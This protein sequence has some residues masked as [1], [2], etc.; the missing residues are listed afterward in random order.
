MRQIMSGTVPSVD[1]NDFR[2]MLWN[3]PQM[4]R[5][6][7]HVALIGH[8]GCGKSTLALD[9]LLPMRKF[10]SILATKPYSPTLKQYIKANRY[11]QYEAWPDKVPALKSPRRAIWPD[12]RTVGRIANQ[13]YQIGHA[14]ER[15]YAEGR[16]CVYAD[17]LRYV[18]DDLN[19]STLVELMLQ[20]GRELGISF[21]GGMQRPKFVPLL[22]YS[23]S[24]HLFFWR[25]RD[26]SNLE[27]I[28][29]INMVDSRFTAEVITNLAPHEFLYINTRLDPERGG[30][31][32][33]ILP[34]EGR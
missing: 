23:Q 18:S 10:V 29:A 6:G 1:W 30:M 31:L 14:M 21:V 25:E 33:S 20:Q 3:G 12:V 4:W 5:Q 28:S 2:E 8:T 16:W 7:E 27:R 24:T 32:R 34:I 17:E 9:G 26:W 19:L 13:R 11:E 15:M 22:V